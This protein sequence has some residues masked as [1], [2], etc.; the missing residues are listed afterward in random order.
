MQ[1]WW[2]TWTQKIGKDALKQL[3]AI[4]MDKESS[5]EQQLCYLI[6]IRHDACTLKQNTNTVRL[7]VQIWVRL[8]SSITSLK[9]FLMVH[10]Q[11]FC[12]LAWLRVFVYEFI[13][14]YYT[15][16]RDCCC[17]YHICYWLHPVLLI[18]IWGEGLLYW[19]VKKKKLESK[20]VLVLCS[21]PD[22]WISIL[23]VISEIFNRMT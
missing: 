18:L 16:A 20:G 5:R 23:H 1:P 15:F 10:S 22:I 11:W 12:L 14:K 6:I 7:C 4:S 19:K 21:C 13:L 2:S 9:Y 17:W 3:T 8:D